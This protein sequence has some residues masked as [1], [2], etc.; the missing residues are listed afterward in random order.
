VEVGDQHRRSAGAVTRYWGAASR[1]RVPSAADDQVDN[2]GHRDLDRTSATLTMSSA[3]LCSTL[4]A[5]TGLFRFI[6]HSGESADAMQVR[7]PFEDCAWMNVRVADKASASSSRGLG[8]LR[9]ERRVSG[10]G[11][12]LVSNSEDEARDV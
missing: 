10:D 6:P 4:L 1:E 8:R 7:P 9:F 12:T 3:V 11:W 5:Q 2:I